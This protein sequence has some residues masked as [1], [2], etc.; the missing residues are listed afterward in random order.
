MALLIFK[1]QDLKPIVEHAL[2]SPAHTPTYAMQLDPAYWREG[3]KVAPGGWPGPEDLD[4]S[5]VKP[6][7]QLVKDEGVY[8]MSS[9]SPR[10]IDPSVQGGMRSLVAYAEGMG[11]EDGW[12]SWQAVGGDDFVE[13]VDVGFIKKAL[14]LGADAIRITLTESSLAIDFEYPK[15][16]P[17]KRAK[18]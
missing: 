7:L 11:P 6:H 12:E 1:A 18:R 17:S 14:D 4:L 13:H 8:L 9:G 5:K 3:A 2:A 16:A 10:L 15:G